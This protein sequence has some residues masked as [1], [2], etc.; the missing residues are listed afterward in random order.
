[1]SGL[2][3]PAFGAA[4]G[5]VIDRLEGGAQLVTDTGG[6]TKYGISRNAHPDVDIPNLTR[7]AAEK[8]YLDRYWSIVHAGDFP[9]ALGLLV[10]DT[11][12]NMGSRKAIQLLQRVLNLR[13]D[14]RVGPKTISAARA[15]D[16]QSELRALYN[17]IRLREYEELAAFKPKYRPYLRGWRLR[18]LRVADEAGRWGEAA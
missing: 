12:V 17:E 6:E 16:P 7:P 15:F 18:V 13:E 14:G 10:F 4:V 1:M 3:G 9:P 11:A 2:N 5:F 8:L